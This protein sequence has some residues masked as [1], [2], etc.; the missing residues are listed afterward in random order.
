MNKR[1]AKKYACGI[2]AI[3]ELAAIVSEQVGDANQYLAAVLP[4]A[5]QRR[6]VSATEDIADEMYRRAGGEVLAVIVGKT[7]YKTGT[8]RRRRR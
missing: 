2:L 7:R 3:E 5:D 1:E 8:R 4:I 6:I